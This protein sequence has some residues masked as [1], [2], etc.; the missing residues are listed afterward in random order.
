MF[1]RRA[2]LFGTETRKATSVRTTL[3]RLWRYF[4]HYAI[5]LVLVVIAVI[6]G[7]YMQVLIPDLTGQDC[8]R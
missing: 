7:T 8:R 5:A 2:E 4:G 3:W 1:D 6:G